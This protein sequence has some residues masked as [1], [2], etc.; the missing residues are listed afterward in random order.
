MK[1]CHALPILFLHEILRR[2]K[3]LLTFSR[4]QM[5]LYSVLKLH[6]KGT[7]SYSNKVK[8]KMK[9]QSSDHLQHYFRFIL[10]SQG[11]NHNF[12]SNFLNLSTLLC[13]NDLEISHWWRLRKKNGIKL[14]YK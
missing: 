11:S 8:N 3:I 6:I 10:H 13:G 12:Y 1:V 14:F 5:M 4:H 9:H 2:S 7:L